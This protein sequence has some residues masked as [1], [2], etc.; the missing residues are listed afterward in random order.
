RDWSSDV[1][2]SDLGGLQQGE[3]PGS[4]EYAHAH[5]LVHDLRDDA[6]TGVDHPPGVLARE[7]GIVTDHGADIVHVALRLHEPLAGVERFE[8]SDVVLL[9]LKFVRESA[10]QICPL[11]RRRFPPRAGV[12][13]LA[14]RGD[15]GAGILR[16]GFRD[17]DD[18]LAISGAVEF[19]SRPIGGTYPLAI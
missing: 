12:E 3:V 4:D 8:A 5:G 11:T 19:S 16:G 10:K 9:V 15:G 14:G 1:C 13:S 17:G 2:S 18:V 7:L 6:R